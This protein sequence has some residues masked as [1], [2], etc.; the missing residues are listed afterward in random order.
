MN[1][2]IVKYRLEIKEEEVKLNK[3]GTEDSKSEP[4]NQKE[5]ILDASC[6]PLD[7]SY[8]TDLGLL[9]YQARKQT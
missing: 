1:R 8:L 4:T 2:E 6:A 7:I 9:L 5:L 3:S